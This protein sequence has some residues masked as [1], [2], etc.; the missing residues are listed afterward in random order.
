MEDTQKLDL[1]D[2]WLEQLQQDFSSARITDDEM[3]KAMRNIHAEFD[4]FIDPHTAIAVA[5]AE[6]LGYNLDTASKDSTYAILSTASPCKFQESV[7]TA[8]GEEGWN[9]YFESGFP[10]RAIDIISKE[11]CKPTAYEWPDGMSFEEVQG[12]WEVQA[13]ELIMEKFL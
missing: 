5:A 12:R 6:K 13:R 7:T 10:L 1:S 8:M 4:Y 9:K 11:E 2:S 3:C